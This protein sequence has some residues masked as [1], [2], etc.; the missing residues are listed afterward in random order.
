MAGFSEQLFAYATLARD[1]DGLVELGELLDFIQRIPHF[2]ADTD[3]VN[4][5]LWPPFFQR[6]DADLKSHIRHGSVSFATN[7]RRRKR[8]HVSSAIAIHKCKSHEPGS[9]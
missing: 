6:L 2:W 7:F 8:N 5:L 3:K 9:S 1:Q 4:R